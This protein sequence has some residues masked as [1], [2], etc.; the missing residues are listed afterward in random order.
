M[1]EPARITCDPYKPE[2]PAENVI[3]CFF[4]L[5]FPFIPSVDL[6]SEKWS[7]AIVAGFY[8]RGVESGERVKHFPPITNSVTD[9]TR[10]NTVP[11]V[12]GVC[13]LH[14]PRGHL[15]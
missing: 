6:S 8:R 13:A 11:G 10:G 15:P 9:K 1:V 3:Q 14:L 5:R 4:P 7:F 12:P 2:I